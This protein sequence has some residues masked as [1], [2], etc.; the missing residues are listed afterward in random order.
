MLENQPA[1]FQQSCL[2]IIDI[3]NF[4]QVNDSYGH[5]TGDLVIQAVAESLKE[6]VRTSDLL[7]RYG[8]DEFLVLIEN[9]SLA[10]ALRI[11]EKIRKSVAKSDVFQPENFER[12]QVSISAGVAVGAGSWMG[13]LAKQMKLCFEPGKRKEYGFELILFKVAKFFCLTDAQVP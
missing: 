1:Q 12:V 7:V 8:G 10:T 4:K 5:I 2:I 3:D 11:A 6:S 13:L 9:I